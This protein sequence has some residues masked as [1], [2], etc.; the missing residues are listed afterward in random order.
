MSK[1]IVSI[2]PEADF[3]TV[4]YAVLGEGTDHVQSLIEQRGTDLRIV[5]RDDDELRAFMRKPLLQHWFELTEARQQDLR[6]TLQYLL[7]IDEHWPYVVIS[8]RNPDLRAKKGALSQHYRDSCQDALT[9]YDGYALCQ[10]MWEILFGDE[11]WHTDISDWV[12]VGRAKEIRLDVSKHGES[13]STVSSFITKLFG[14][15]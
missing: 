6:H 4:I 3:F 13:P 8:P 12:I 11:D 10:W 1:E 14:K 7:N 15:K 9:P 2:D 5:L